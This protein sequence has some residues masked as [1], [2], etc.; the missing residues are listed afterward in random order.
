MLEILRAGIQT[1]VQD[2]GR[3]GY[4][5]LGVA[6]CGALDAPAM[7]LANRL[8]NN[9]GSAAGLEVVAG[10]VQ[11]RFLDERW[12]ALCGADFQATLDGVPLACGWRNRARPGQ[13]LQL[14][15]SSEGMCVCLAVGGGI[16]VPCVMG[17]RATD[18]R[19]GFGGM[20]GRALHAGDRLPL[21]QAYPLQTRLGTPQRHWTPEVRVLRGPEYA[22]FDAAA[23]GAF[24]RQAW[25][26]STHSNRMGYR[27]QGPKLL[28]TID[29]D[30][31]SHAVIPGVV[32]VPP[33]GPPIV[34]LA[35]AQTTG[36]YPRIAVVIDADLWKFGQAPPGRQFC[37]VETDLDGAHA[38]REQWRH[39]LYRFE[40]SLYG[41]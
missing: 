9:A 39:E 34:L 13:V 16:D 1:T 18:L 17:S 2:Q 11:L 26:V 4:R 23:R 40:W 35:D 7:W 15:G 14:L 28:R 33:G 37:F 38:A 22:Q 12:F 3:G 25:T 10:P 32:Q 21:A 41:K 29:S 30:L 31:P 20:D 19:A 5:H 6:L 8:V 36:G 27:L 24:W